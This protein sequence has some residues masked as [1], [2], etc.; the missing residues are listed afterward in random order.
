LGPAPATRDGNLVRFNHHE[1]ASRLSYLFWASMPDDKLFTAA[2]NGKLGTP[3]EIANEARRMLSDPRARA[4]LND[5]HIQWLRIGELGDLPKDPSITD[6]SPEVA[7]SMLKE[8]E[9]FIANVFQG[10][11]ADGKLETLLTSPASYIDGNL[12]KIYGVKNLQGTNM[13]P[14]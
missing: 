7:K 11:K 13:Q 12:A 2:D 6:Y 3:D 5:F 14:V 1:V 4:A 8:T 9:E 10:P